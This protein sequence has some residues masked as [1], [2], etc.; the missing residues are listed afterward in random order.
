V[1]FSSAGGFVI[2]YASTLADGSGRGIYYRDYDATGLARGG[3]LVNTTTL[4]DQD[5]P[6]LAIQP[7][8]GMIIAWDGNGSGD[9]SGIFAQ[10]YLEPGIVVSQI[11]NNTAE[12][13]G[14]ATFSVVLLTQPTANVTINL[15]SSDLTEGTLSVGS[16]TFNSA[17][18]NTPQFVT[19]TGVDD[20]VD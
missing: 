18:W 7:S 12:N 14:S 2:T 10:R 6:A 17:N 19:V 5:R 11:S 3:A 9:A 20:F 15:S 16:V 4:N 13:G 1:A 8:G